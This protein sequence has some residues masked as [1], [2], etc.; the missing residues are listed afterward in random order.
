MYMY[1]QDHSLAGCYCFATFNTKRIILGSSGVDWSVV[2]LQAALFPTY[3]GSTCTCCIR[4]RL[5]CMSGE[6]ALIVIKH[7][8][9]AYQKETVM[10][11]WHHNLTN[12]VHMQL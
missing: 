1:V 6:G 7:A 11:V 4:E 8:Q 3:A 2:E 9:M 10:C 5:R 12:V